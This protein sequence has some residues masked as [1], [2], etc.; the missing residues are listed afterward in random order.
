MPPKKPCKKGTEKMLGMWADFPKD[1]LKQLTINSENNLDRYDVEAYINKEN[2]IDQSK[3]VILYAYE[4]E[5][6]D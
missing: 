3:P 2:Q 1:V 4:T 5:G 6:K